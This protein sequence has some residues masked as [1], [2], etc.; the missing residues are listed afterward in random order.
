MATEILQP[1][2]DFAINWT[3]VPADTSNFSAVDEG[4]AAP[5]DADKLTTAAKNVAD[6][7]DFEDSAL[8]DADTITRVDVKVRARVTGGGANEIQADLIIGGVSQ[9]TVNQ[10][11]VN[12]DPFATFTLNLA[13]WNSDWTAAQLDGM[14]VIV[15]SIQTGMPTASDWEVSVVEAIVTYTPSGP[16]G[17]PHYYQHLIGQGA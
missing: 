12:S 2:G 11:L 16:S 4:S 5:D 14:R 17:A 8:V 9:G 3:R 6:E 7:F 15:K 13:A 10:A 1:N